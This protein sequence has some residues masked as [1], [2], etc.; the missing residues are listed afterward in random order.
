MGGGGGAPQFYR[1]KT[2]DHT[3]IESPRTRQVSHSPGYWRELW[4]ENPEWCVM[5]RGLLSCWVLQCGDNNIKSTSRERGVTKHSQSVKTV[6]C[7]H[8]ARVS[9]VTDSQKTPYI[10]SIFP[11]CRSWFP[12][13]PPPSIAVVNQTALIEFSPYAYIT[14]YLD[15]RTE[16]GWAGGGFRDVITPISYFSRR[17]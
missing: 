12:Q 5:L 10:S 14:T 7:S 11:E 1:I 2:R 13:S 16:L 4:Q 17:H 15:W 6:A 3:C 9:V 8:Q